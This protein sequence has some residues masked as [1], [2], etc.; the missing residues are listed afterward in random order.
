[1]F[2]YLAYLGTDLAGGAGTPRRESRKQF[3]EQGQFSNR[4][5]VDSMI[6]SRDADS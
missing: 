1:M 5:F 3:I 4:S 2:Q 6:S